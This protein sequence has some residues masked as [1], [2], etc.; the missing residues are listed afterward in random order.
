MVTVIHPNLEAID[1][2]MRAKDVSVF[3]SDKQAIDNVSID[4]PDVPEDLPPQLGVAAGIL[5]AIVGTLGTVVLG[6]AEAFGA[7]YLSSLYRDGISYGVMI[8][9]I[10]LIPAGLFGRVL[11]ETKKSM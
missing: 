1:A 2:K 3:Y 7:G 6:V 11:K 10:I 8:I 4:I 5:M 9:V